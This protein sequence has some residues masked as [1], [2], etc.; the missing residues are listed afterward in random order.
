MALDRILHGG[1][2]PRSLSEALSDREAHDKL[3]GMFR[4]SAEAEGIDWPGE[5]LKAEAE[6]AGDNVVSLHS[7]TII[8]LCE[9]AAENRLFYQT[10]II[11]PF[12][13]GQSAKLSTGRTVTVTSIE[14]LAW[15][16]GTAERQR[17][18][19]V[20]WETERAERGMGRFQSFSD[21]PRE[22]LVPVGREE[23]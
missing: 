10:D 9:A 23:R 3:H 15:N 14:P 18:Y 2:K 17:I 21:W 11:P 8:G 19:R 16:D 6:T 1:A 12:R 13:V 22:A 4:A 5:L 20:H 7:R